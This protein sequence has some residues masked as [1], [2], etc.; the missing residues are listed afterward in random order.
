[1]NLWI[2]GHFL[3][4]AL[5][6]S[7]SAVMLDECGPLIKPLSMD[8]PDVMYG[9]SNFLVGYSDSKIFND[10]MNITLSA[11]LNISASPDGEGGLVLTEENNM[12]GTCIGSTM[13]LTIENDVARGAFADLQSGFQ[14]LPTC[15]G[16]LLFTINSTSKNIKKVLEVFKINTSV[17]DSEFQ[18]RSL[19]LLSRET[20][21][22]DADI[23]KLKKQAS[24]LGFVGEP[25]F[26]YNPDHGFCKEGEGIRLQ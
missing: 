5:V 10:I 15:E 2:K 18:A 8:R 20:T 26:V 25:N 22:T 11:W 17:E 4:A 1:M 13:N 6:V 9:R 7:C 19:Y 23:E 14:L 16:C 3:F 24:C 12:N 21:V